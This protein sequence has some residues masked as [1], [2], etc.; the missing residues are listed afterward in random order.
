[1][2]KEC[3]NIANE[4]G[5][6]EHMLHF[7]DFGN[8]GGGDLGDAFEV[9]VDEPDSNRHET[10]TV[11]P[12]KTLLDVLNDAGFDILYSCKSGACGACKVA[13]CEGKVE[14]KST[15]LLEKEKGRALQACV[16]R[17]IGRLKIEID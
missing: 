9:Q 11:P 13:I 15:A 3:A 12:N 8:G 16:D 4:L 7:E 1:M 5:Y 14:Y 6:P 17:G 10:M 2:M